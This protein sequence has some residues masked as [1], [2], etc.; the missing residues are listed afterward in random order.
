MLGQTNDQPSNLLPPEINFGHLALK[1]TKFF[2]RALQILSCGNESLL[3]YLD[4]RVFG[5]H[6]PP[7]SSFAFLFLAARS[8]R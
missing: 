4:K 8:A 1:N 3:A 7:S 6:Y 2:D 5:L